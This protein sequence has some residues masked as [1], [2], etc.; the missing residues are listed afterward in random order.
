MFVKVAEGQVSAAGETHIRLKSHRPS[1]LTAGEKLAISTSRTQGNKTMVA[2]K[3]NGSM[4]LSDSADK[5]NSLTVVGGQ[6][7]TGTSSKF[8]TAKNSIVM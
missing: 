3:Q 1:V 5:I 4:S 8:N 2:F 6:N 7:E